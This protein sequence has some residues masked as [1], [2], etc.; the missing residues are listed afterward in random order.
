M[1]NISIG[2]MSDVVPIVIVSR[3]MWPHDDIAANLPHMEI[4]AI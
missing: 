3:E 4:V 1:K 2:R